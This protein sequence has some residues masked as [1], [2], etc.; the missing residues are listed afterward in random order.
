MSEKQEVFSLIGGKVKFYRGIYN[1]TSDAVWL[2]AFVPDKPK[3]VLDVGIGTGGVALCL[4]SHQNNA[5]ITGLD[6]SGDMLVECAKNAELNG[7]DIELINADIFS[8][9]TA[10]TFD[11]VVSNPPYFKGTPAHHNAHHNVDISGWVKKCVARV[12]PRGWFCTIVDTLVLADTIS[13][14]SKSCGDITI[15]PLYGSKQTAERVLVRGRV[16]TKGGTILYKGLSMNDSGVLRDGL[17]IYQKLSKL[18]T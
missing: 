17:T 12:R 18:D 16:G 5:Q 7:C 14:M 13:V 1:P 3:T 4:Y 8:W 6:I 10:R 15:L 11:V 9:K 2:A